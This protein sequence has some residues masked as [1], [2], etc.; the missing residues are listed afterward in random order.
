MRNIVNADDI[1]TL[2]NKHLIF[3]IIN[4]KYGIPP[5]WMREP[6]FISLSRIILEQQVS[7]ESAKA[8]FEKINSYIPEFTP[9]EIIKLS[10]QEMRDCQISRQKAKYLRSL[11]EA[12]LKNELNLEVMDTF[13]DHEIREKLTKIN[14]IGNWTVDIYLMFCLQRK[15]VFPS[16]DIAVINAAMELLEYETKDEVLNESKKWAP[17]RSLAAYFLWHYYLKKRNR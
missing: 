16:G 7:I 14:G 2:C 3:R 1:N 9:N 4:D 8:H 12:I 11:S 5:N 10:D 6:G 15:D 17:L 13:N